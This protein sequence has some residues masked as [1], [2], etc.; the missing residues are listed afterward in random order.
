MATLKI[1]KIEGREIISSGGDPTVEAC[2]TLSSG[3]SAKASVPFGV[4]DGTHEAYILHDND[5]KRFRGKGMLKAVR[6]VSTIINKTLQGMPI[7]DLKNIDHAMLHKDGTKNKS[8]L[9]GNALLAVSIACARASAEAAQRPLYSHLRKAFGL[10]FS[11]WVLPKPMMVTIEGGRHADRSTDFQEYMLTPIA[12]KKRRELIR[13]GLEAYASVRDIL[14]KKGYATN[15]GNEGAFT[16]PL[17]SNESPLP[18]LV[19]GIKQAGYRPGKDIALSL[20]PAVSEVYTKGMYVMRL[21]KKRFTASQMTSLFSKWIAKYPIV[22]L[23]DPLAEDDWDN[24]SML[25]QKLSKKVKIVGDDLTVTNKE[26]LQ[27]AIDRKAINTILI[28][29]NQI[30]T[31]TEMMDTIRLAAKNNIGTIISHRG[32]GETGDT[33]IID[34]GVAANSLYYKIGPTR[35]ER[36]EKYNRLLEIEDELF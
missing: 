16:P 7:A 34:L 30:G 11:G 32:G 35:G 18:I 31:V 2:V 26:R 13:M 19:E 14:K 10:P 5:P 8:K 29:P 12:N 15:V 24:W 4:S 6:N 3:V 22:T 25:F 28:K 21:D 1:K 27:E 17:P 23:E 20:D 9:G 36:T 33:F